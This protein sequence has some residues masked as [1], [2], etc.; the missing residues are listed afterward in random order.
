MSHCVS[1]VMEREAG[2][3]LQVSEALNEQE[4]CHTR[5]A[6]LCLSERI[7]LCLSLPSPWNLP[8][9]TRSLS[10]SSAHL[11]PPHIISKTSPSLVLL[12]FNVCATVLWVKVVLSPKSSFTDNH[13][14]NEGSNGKA[15]QLMQNI[16]RIEIEGVK[17]NNAYENK[18]WT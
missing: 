4:R 12:L 15:R 6:L 7:N 11:Q 13:H 8:S 1:A 10:I 14:H 2:L 3:C 17:R 16:H 5:A 9:P 18:R